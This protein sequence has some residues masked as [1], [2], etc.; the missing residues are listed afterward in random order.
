MMD[1]SVVILIFQ[2]KNTNKTR[3]SEDMFFFQRWDPE[4]IGSVQLQP[5]GMSTDE[6]APKKL[7]SQ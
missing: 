2:G 6:F 3:T 4:R 1:F 5:S 7:P